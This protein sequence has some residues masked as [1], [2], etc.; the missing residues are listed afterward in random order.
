LEDNIFFTA[1]AGK[2]TGG[3][4]QRNIKM[5]TIKKRIFPPASNTKFDFEKS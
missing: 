4:S 1:L 2:E 5:S 3:V